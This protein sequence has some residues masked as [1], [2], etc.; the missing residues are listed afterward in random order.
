MT[1]GTN[2]LLRFLCWLG[3]TFS[4]AV[5]SGLLSYMARNE[6]NHTAFEPWLLSA[7]FVPTG[8]AGI[9]LV[10]RVRRFAFVAIVAVVVSATGMG[11]LYYIDHTN[12]M[13]QYERWLSR[14]MPL[15]SR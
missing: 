2:R 14:D 11:L 8:I 10:V 9:C 5:A 7:V 1:E 12:R 6:T 13:L 3:A 4:I 15:P